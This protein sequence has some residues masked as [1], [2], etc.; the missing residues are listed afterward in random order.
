MSVLVTLMIEMIVLL[1]RR[2]V[3]ETAWRKVREIWH[4]FIPC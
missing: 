3:L 2:I 4:T 1:E